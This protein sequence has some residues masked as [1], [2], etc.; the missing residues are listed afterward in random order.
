MQQTLLGLSAL[1]PTHLGSYSDVVAGASV[2]ENLITMDDL[3]AEFELWIRAGELERKIIN[4]AVLALECCSKRCVKLSNVTMLLK[5]LT[6]IPE[7]TAQAQR[8]FSKVKN[9]VCC[10]FLD[11]GRTS[12]ESC[13]HSGTHGQNT[14]C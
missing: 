6:T 5:I 13:T 9:S 2:Y 3:P 7:T 1:I 10:A 12:G 14:A 11:V 4:T 8:V